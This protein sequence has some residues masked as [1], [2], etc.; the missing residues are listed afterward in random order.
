MQLATST[1]LQN[2]IISQIGTSKITTE[3]YQEIQRK[4]IEKER[5]LLTKENEQC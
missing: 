2:E 1:R 3:R 5:A 4:A